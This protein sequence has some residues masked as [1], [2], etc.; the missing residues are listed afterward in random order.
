MQSKSWVFQRGTLSARLLGTLLVSIQ[1]I[2]AQPKALSGDAAYNPARDGGSNLVTVIGH[3]A[4]I[5]A[6]LIDEQG[7][8]LLEA[9]GVTLDAFGL[10]AHNTS[11]IQW[12][13]DEGFYPSVIYT[14]E[15]P[16]FS[17]SLTYFAY[18]KMS[19]V[20]GGDFVL[21]YVRASLTYTGT[22]TTGTVS[23]DI[24]PPTGLTLIAPHAMPTEI[25]LENESMVNADFAIA[26]ERISGVGDHTLPP[27]EI[28][29]IAG[30]FNDAQTAM[31]EFWD[32][33]LARQTT[34]IMPEAASNSTYINNAFKVALIHMQ[35]IRDGN[36]LHIGEN[37][38]DYVYDHDAQG[39]MASAMEMGA[40]TFDE[41]VALLKN[42][43]AQKASHDYIDALGKLPWAIA[44]FAQKFQPDSSL[45][46]ELVST[47]LFSGAN[48]MTKPLSEWM[49][50]LVDEK[51]EAD[52]LAVSAGTLDSDNR[53]TVD[54]LAILL[55]LKAYSYLCNYLGDTSQKQWA[56]KQYQITS[57]TLQSTLLNLVAEKSESD[58]YV[59][60]GVTILTEDLNFGGQP[61]SWQNAN[62][63]SHFFFGR[64]YELYL[65]GGELSDLVPY[66]DNTLDVGISQLQGNEKFITDGSWNGNFGTYGD[67]YCTS[68]YNAS[69]AE[70][71]L[72]GKGKYRT[73]Y[74]KAFEYLMGL[75]T[76]PYSW[77]ESVGCAED[78]DIV[79]EGQ[80]TGAQSGNGSAPHVWS[81]MSQAR[82]LALTLISEKYNGTLIVG[83]G[84]PTDWL[85]LGPVGVKNYKLSNGTRFEYTISAVNELEYRFSFTGTPVND[86]ILNL[87]VFIT[88][89]VQLKQECTDPDNFD[90]FINLTDIDGDGHKEIH[91]KHGYKGPGLTFTFSEGGMPECNLSSQELH[92]SSSSN[93]ISMSS[94][95]MSAESSILSS[96]NMVS[97]NASVTAL[98]G[99][100]N[101]SITKVMVKN[102]GGEGS[103]FIGNLQNQ[104]TI[105]S[106]HGAKLFRGVL[107]DGRLLIPSS[108][109]PGVLLFE[110]HTSN[111]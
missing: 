109:T 82:L 32:G 49:H 36:E 24:A 27:Q 12:R 48:A 3:K 90:Q 21:L 33:E 67:T 80:Q 6:P 42:L 78:Y 68:G 86:M 103:V 79:I 7:R 19:T 38:Y 76:G 45:V 37:G 69:Y 99:N 13:L 63:Y 72:L 107:V 94:S 18:P 40:L 44:K 110:L 16:D 50:Y 92:V 62:A 2:S 53:A 98:F 52:G 102:Y 89:Q 25:N 59:S 74:Y 9:P 10:L 11:A 8:V 47:H 5:E 108:V 75:Q 66:I 15:V 91:I 93:H 39:N 20:Q 23:I 97:S 61:D 56:E 28:E 106:I 55:G 34:L 105:Y 84:L 43:P 26:T 46:R 35:I 29:N 64:M 87:P 95:A 4:Q 57:S 60:V 101:Y 88:D 54:N 1:L 22:Q 51:L 71:L 30:S 65:L 77:F 111:H 96:N 73:T 31:K 100:T 41:A 58:K 81:S 14:F 104:V 70:G 85:A 83:R 17:V